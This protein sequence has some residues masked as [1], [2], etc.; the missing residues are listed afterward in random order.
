MGIVGTSGI[1][2]PSL[3]TKGDGC[4]LEARFE[5]ACL[6]G[7][8]RFSYRKEVRPMVVVPVGPSF[9]GDF[10]WNRR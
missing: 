2:I 6:L 5:V 3:T 9:R 1:A 4:V 7:R 8:S 10:V